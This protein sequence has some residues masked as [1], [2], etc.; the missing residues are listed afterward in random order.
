[1][2]GRFANFSLRTFLVQQRDRLF[3]RTHLVTA[4][5]AVAL[6]MLIWPGLGLR[7]PLYEVGEIAPRTVR[8]TEDFT[9]EDAATTEARRREAVEQVPE[10]YDFDSQARDEVRARIAR[11][12]DFGRAAVETDIVGEPDF[13]ETFAGMLG[14]EVTAGATGAAGGVGV[15]RGDRA[16]PGRTPWPACWR[17]TSSRR[18]APSPRSAAPCCA[19]IRGREKRFPWRTSRTCCRWAKPSGRPSSRSSRS[20]N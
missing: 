11:G 19:A 1:M 6:A 5:L 14:I 13:A 4:L 7:T 8:A 20:P 10:V 3:A 18:R 16:E 9:Y 2:K 17:A 15:R 12:F